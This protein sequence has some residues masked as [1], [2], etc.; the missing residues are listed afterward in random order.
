MTED[1]KLTAE[2]ISGDY[3]NNTYIAHIKVL[4]DGE[5]VGDFYANFE[6]YRDKLVADWSTV[7][8][9]NGL[10]VDQEPPFWPVEVIAEELDERYE[11]RDFEAVNSGPTD[12]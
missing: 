12:K 3:T 2:L 6:K 1:S 9:G 11:L 7:K 5:W 4:Q 10:Y 8:K